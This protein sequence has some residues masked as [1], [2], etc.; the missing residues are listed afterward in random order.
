VLVGANPIERLLQVSSIVHDLITWAQIAEVLGEP[1][2]G[3]LADRSHLL[4][5]LAGESTGVGIGRASHNRG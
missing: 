3:R 2:N 5:D 1:A 4:D